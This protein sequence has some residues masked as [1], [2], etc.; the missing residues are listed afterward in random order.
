MC[1]GSHT[2]TVDTFV[3]NTTSGAGLGLEKIRI[4]GKSGYFDGNHREGGLLQ[5]ECKHTGAS[6]EIYEHSAGNYIDTGY[7]LVEPLEDSTSQT[8]YTQIS[9]NSTITITSPSQFSV[10]DE[11][12]LSGF[13]KDYT[14]DHSNSFYDSD[15][16]N[17]NGG[18]AYFKKRIVLESAEDY[19]DIYQ[20]H[21]K[22][23]NVNNGVFYRLNA[24]ETTLASAWT[25]FAGSQLESGIST[26][27]GGA[28]YDGA[29]LKIG[30]LVRLRGILAKTDANFSGTIFVKIATLPSGY[31][32]AKII[33]LGY[34]LSSQIYLNPNGDVKLSILT[35][36][37]QLAFVSLDNISF[38]IV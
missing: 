5:I 9:S 29:Y 25:T 30:N 23:N 14:A 17:R 16:M 22:T 8:N 35:S 28:Y 15:F 3:S 21:S 6:Y 33:Q 27:L 32:P 2:I 18:N 36:S 24:L 13:S 7:S 10:I 20:L 11:V 38:N 26:N 1:K 31:R 34:Q 19:C 12:D 37:D 4:K